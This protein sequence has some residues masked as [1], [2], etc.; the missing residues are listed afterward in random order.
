MDTLSNLYR[1]ALDSALLLLAHGR[2]YPAVRTETWPRLPR[3][4]TC[5]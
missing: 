1:R 2:D 4:I 5:R 3:I